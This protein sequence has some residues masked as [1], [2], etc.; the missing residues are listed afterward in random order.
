MLRPWR[1]F[2]TVSVGVF[3]SLLDLFIVNITFPDLQRDFAGTSLSTLSWVLN[4]YAIVFAALLVPAGRIADLIGRKRGFVVGLLLFVL[5]S[6]AC[7]A[8][9][10]AYAL[11]AGRVVQAVGAA[12]LTPSSLGVV[13][14]EFPPEQRRSV[15]A[16]WAA[17][18]ALG[19]AAGPP[20]GGLLVQLRWRWVFVVNLPLGLVS[21]AFAIRQLRETKDPSG[22]RLPDL[23]GSVLL[24]AGVAA[25]TL[26]LTKAADWGWAGAATLSAFVV[27]A[28]LV[29]LAVLRS[30]GHP[31]PALDLSMLRLPRFALAVTS[32]F[33]FFAGFAG[34]LLAGVLFLTDVWGQSI[35][36]TGFELT[37]GPIM[38]LV[39]AIVASRLG[40]R[41]GLGVIG[42]AGGVLVAAS[43]TWNATRLGLSPH[44]LTRLLPS[45]IVGGAGIGL[46]MPSFTAIAVGSVHPA[47]ISTAIG[48]SSMFRQ[49]GGALG[50]AAFVAILG[51]PARDDALIAFRHGWVFMAAACIAGAL[52]MLA[53][54]LVPASL[55][56]RAGEPRE[57]ETEQVLDGS[58]SSAYTLA[59]RGSGGRSDVRLHCG[60]SSRSG[61]RPVDNAGI[62]ADP[63][64]S[65]KTPRPRGARSGGVGARVS[66]L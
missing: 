49:L 14:P 7:A 66:C 31:A 51:T 59:D 15:I 55:P 53:A 57:R 6:A 23:A 41:I 12:I 19:A 20:L 9:P 3:A 29:T 18:G 33:C 48:I 27:A 43:L 34:L 1:I 37:P 2:A 30:A 4:G 61:E 8:A 58:E 22:G 50:I 35:L 32:A 36:L 45:Q 40:G 10:S 56:P 65:P 24:M 62:R 11:I 44:Y 64:W 25:A 26:G 28:A 60:S 46:A 13:L 17:V 21:V 42:A 52:G 16:G 63:A 54:H 38:A 39:F 5:A 47:R